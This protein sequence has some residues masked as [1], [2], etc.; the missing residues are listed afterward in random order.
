MCSILDPLQAQVLLHKYAHLLAHEAARPR[1]ENYWGPMVHGML[2][3]CISTMGIH[4][5]S[6]PDAQ[7]IPCGSLW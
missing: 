6:I 1:V 4:G 2:G 3:Q 5:E 7:N